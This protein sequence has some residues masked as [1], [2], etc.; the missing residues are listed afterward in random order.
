MTVLRGKR[1]ASSCQLDQGRFVVIIAKP[2]GETPALL[3]Q[4][5][6]DL[7]RVQRRAL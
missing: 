7:H 1:R 3:Q 5:F 6:R 2:A 4:L